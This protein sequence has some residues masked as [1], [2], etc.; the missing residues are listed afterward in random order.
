MACIKGFIE[1]GIEVNWVDFWVFEG[2]LREEWD[3]LFW[4]GIFCSIKSD[5]INNCIKSVDFLKRIAY[6]KSIKYNERYI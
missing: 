5:V 4:G 2:I 6:N 1:L 3:E